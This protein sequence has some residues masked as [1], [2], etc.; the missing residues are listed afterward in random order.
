[1]RAWPSSAVL[2]RPDVYVGIHRGYDLRLRSLVFESA[3][4]IAFL[5]RETPCVLKKE[6]DRAP[7]VRI[8]GF[9]RV[10]EQALAHV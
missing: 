7:R 5:N 10:N 8:G 2:L 6:S 4:K 3:P 9:Y 1:M